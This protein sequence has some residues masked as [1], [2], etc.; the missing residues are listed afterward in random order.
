MKHTWIYQNPHLHKFQKQV[1]FFI[2]AGAKAASLV[3]NIASA[4]PTSAIF[5]CLRSLPRPP[6]PIQ[7]PIMYSLCQILNPDISTTRKIRSGARHF[8]NSVIRPG[9]KL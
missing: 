8:Q 2:P 5:T 7:T 9:R 4:V 3:P 6:L 1:L